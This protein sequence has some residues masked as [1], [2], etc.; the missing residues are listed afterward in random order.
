MKDNHKYRVSVYLG[1]ADYNNCKG[2]A[3]ELGIP[4]ATMLRMM[5][6][7]G[8]EMVKAYEKGD[9]NNG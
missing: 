5:L 2:M 6:T 3:D 8:F 4:L 1:K 7:M 9:E